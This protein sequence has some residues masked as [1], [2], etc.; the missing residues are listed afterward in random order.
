MSGSGRPRIT[1]ATRRAAS[2]PAVATVLWAI[3]NGII[4]LAWRPDALQREHA[5]LRE[6]LETATDVIADGLRARR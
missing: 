3:W 1:R 5:Q 2:R 4:S 6:L